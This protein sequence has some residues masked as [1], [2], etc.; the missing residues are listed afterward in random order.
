LEWPPRSG[1]IQ[2]FPEVDRAGWFALDVARHKLVSA[3]C[4]FIDRL[5]EV[6]SGPA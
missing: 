2:E 5:S 3:Q 6:V 1:R 4:A